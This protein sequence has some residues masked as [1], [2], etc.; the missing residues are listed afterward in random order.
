MKKIISLSSIACLLLFTGCKKQPDVAP[1]E[2]IETGAGSLE[3]MTSLIW[4]F[5]NVNDSKDK[6]EV[7]FRRT[8]DIYQCDSMNL[9][10]NSTYEINILILNE[11]DLKNVKDVTPIIQ[12]K[13]DFHQFFYIQEPDLGLKFTCLNFDKAGKPYGSKLKIETKDAGEGQLN[14]TLKHY[15]NLAE[16]Q[17]DIKIGATDIDVEFPLFVK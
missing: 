11:T 14:V 12:K 1:E 6:F 10:K 4:Q 16:K 13:D 9:K 7:K 5:T 15:M 2:P 17:G 3:V 8:P